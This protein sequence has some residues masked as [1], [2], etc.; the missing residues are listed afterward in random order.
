MPLGLGVALYYILR[1]HCL[2]ALNGVDIVCP[3]SLHWFVRF[4]LVAHVTLV[5]HLREGNCL[6]SCD[7]I[8]SLLSTFHWKYLCFRAQK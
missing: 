6:S 5:A 8:F 7:V 2:Q 3:C 1:Q 4:V